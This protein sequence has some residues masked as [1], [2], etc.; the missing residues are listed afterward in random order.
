MCDVWLC[1]LH[2]PFPAHSHTIYYV[3]DGIERTFWHFCH[4][5]PDNN[6]NSIGCILF[7][8]FSIAIILYDQ[9]TRNFWWNYKEKENKLSHRFWKLCGCRCVLAI[10]VCDFQFCNFLV[11]LFVVFFS[12]RFFCSLFHNLLVSFLSF[13]LVR[14]GKAIWF[15]SAFRIQLFEFDFDCEFIYLF[16][17]SVL[18][19]SVCDEGKSEKDKVLMKST[20]ARGNE[21]ETHIDDKY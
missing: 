8:L 3:F 14:F 21:R 10:L 13:Y 1:M 18:M 7:F 19:P 11:Y 17:F 6:F 9:Q 5:C 12:V 20:N 15:D 2:V 16:I 4:I